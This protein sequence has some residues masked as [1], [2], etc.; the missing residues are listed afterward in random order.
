MAVLGSA[1]FPETLAELVIE[2]AAVGV[3][4]IVTVAEAALA[5]VPRLHVTVPPACEQE[6]WLGVAEMKITPA[7]SVSVRITPVAVEGPPLVTVT[8]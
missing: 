1:S 4:E 7:G 8:V 3:S 6:P 5:R 2:P